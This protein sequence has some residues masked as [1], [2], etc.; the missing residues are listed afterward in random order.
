MGWLFLASVLQGQDIHFSQFYNAPLSI[1]PG[2]TGIFGGDV[3]LAATY[4]NQW[5]A[6]SVPFVTYHL[7]VDG[8]IF[9]PRNEKGFFSWG[10]TLFH[11]EAGDISLTNSQVNGSFSYT[12]QLDPQNY[13]TLGL[14]AGLAYNRLGTNGTTTDQQYVDGRFVPTAATGEQF[15]NDDL[16]YPDFGVGLNWHGQLPGKRSRL[17]VGAGLFHLNRPD[18]NFMAD[19]EAPLPMR[20]SLY[21]L[22]TVQLSNRTDLLLTGSAQVQDNYVE[23]LAGLG[24]RIFLKNEPSRE[25][26]LQ[27]SGAVRFNEFSDAIIPGLELQH[28]YWALGATFDINV[29]DFRV[30][31]N[32]NGGPEIHFRYLIHKVRPLK[33]FKN[34]P[35]I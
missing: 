25:V 21:F 11:D 3:R 23:A 27:F 15:S 28:R 6:A 9:N 26:A 16:L 30:A 10:L 4:R 18:Q 14:L 24:L 31:T 34:C 13:L 20:L 19:D 22:P 35:L 1:N 7:S 8:K 12:L 5:S 2:L 33:F 29:S 17:N 32:R